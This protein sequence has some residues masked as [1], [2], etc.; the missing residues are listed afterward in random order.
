M[1]HGWRAA[2][3]LQTASSSACRSEASTLWCML[4]LSCSVAVTD[5]VPSRLAA[6]SCV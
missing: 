1:R 5:L 6:P 3:A 4:T 2:I